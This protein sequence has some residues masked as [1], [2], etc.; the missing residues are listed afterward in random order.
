M[1]QRTGVSMDAAALLAAAHGNCFRAICNMLGRDFVGLTVAARHACREGVITNKM[2]KTLTQLDTAFAFVRHVS[3]PRCDGLCKDLQSMLDKELVKSVGGNAKHVTGKG[4]TV[5]DGENSYTNHAENDAENHAEN[6]HAEQKPVVLEHSLVTQ[7]ATEQQLPA[8][9]TKRR[10]QVSAA[11][12]PEVDTS[13]VA[14]GLDVDL[15]SP[16]FQNDIEND[17]MVNKLL[18]EVRG[19]LCAEFPV[20]L[21]RQCGSSQLTFDAIVERMK[22]I[23]LTSVLEEVSLP[24]GFDL[25]KA[26]D[27][28]D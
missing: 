8:D 22:D 18:K 28:A 26:L 15:K 1:S 21:L 6:D 24:K 9:P 17:A 7:A 5:A 19:D 13:H 16:A 10:E 4:D 11:A 14:G 25:S 20:A 3:L 27:A 12:V 23:I 2:N